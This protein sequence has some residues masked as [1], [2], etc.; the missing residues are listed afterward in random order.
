MERDG[1]IKRELVSEKKMG[2]KA[3][4]VIIKNLSNS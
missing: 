4:K 3:N 1:E 2:T